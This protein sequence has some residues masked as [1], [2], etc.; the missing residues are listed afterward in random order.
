MKH[1]KSKLVIYSLQGCPYSM[2]AV[3]F[4]KKKI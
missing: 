3:D 2:A 4:L 1:N